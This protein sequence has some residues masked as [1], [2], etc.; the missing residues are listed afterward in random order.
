MTSMHAQKILR[1]IFQPAHRPPQQLSRPSRGY[2]LWHPAAFATETP[3]HPRRNNSHIRLFQAQGCRKPPLVFVR[4]LRRQPDGE[5]AVF[6][7]LHKYS[8][9]LQRCHRHAIVLQTDSHDSLVRAVFGRLLAHRKLQSVRATLGKQQHW[10]VS[11][12]IASPSTRLSSC[13]VAST[14]P[15]TICAIAS[16]TASTDIPSTFPAVLPRER[17]FCVHAHR[18]RFVIHHDHLGRVVRRR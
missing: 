7:R 14:I 11:L 13:T 10:S 1:A 4:P 17:S 6:V 8:L 16:A 5:L 2:V 3:A 18:Q 15:N 9:R 12:C